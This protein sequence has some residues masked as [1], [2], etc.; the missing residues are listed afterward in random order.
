MVL[1]LLAALIGRPTPAAATLDRAAA[2]G[3]LTIGYIADARPFSYTDAAGKP[4]G[5]AVALC[6]RIG[7]EARSELKLPA[8]AVNVVAVPFAER[9]RAVDQGSI[10]LLCGAEPTLER[11]K[12]VDFSIP[13]LLS[14]VGVVIRNDA[15]PRLR[16]LLSGQ[17]PKAQ[18]LWRGSRGQAPE[19]HVVAVIG[20]TTLE[21]ALVDKLRASRIV[22]E[23]VPVGDTQA[24]MQMVLQRRADAFFSGRALLL[25]AVRHNA[26][27][28]Q[29]TV[30]DRIF[31][32]S[33]VAL[34][35]PRNDD[36]F[37]LLVDRT[38]SRLMRSGEMSKLYGEHFGAPDSGMLEM[39]R[40][41]ALPE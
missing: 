25:D 13:I 19:R 31:K 18:P 4:A 17:E 39:F 10:D 40:L 26:S 30:L 9:F 15:P 38:L 8:L 35:V 7:E 16:Q 32:R 33:Q 11:R 14:G 27:G 2:S 24:G 37:R 1:L 41:V 36:R 34:A 12:L 21:Q 22:V 23:V 3:Q 20:G 28:G 29:L 5:Y 6:N